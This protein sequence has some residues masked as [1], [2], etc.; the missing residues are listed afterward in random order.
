MPG[1]NNS[2][3]HK[4]LE[5]RYELSAKVYRVEREESISS[6]DPVESGYKVG[7]ITIRAILLAIREGLPIRLVNLA[8]E[9]ELRSQGRSQERL[10]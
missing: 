5:L 10:G 9:R 8:K 6:Q 2:K 4:G 7:S 3:P 1:S